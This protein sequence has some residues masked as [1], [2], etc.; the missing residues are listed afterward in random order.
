MLPC[1]TANIMWAVIR[2]IRTS[3]P[4]CAILGGVGSEKQDIPLCFVLVA[5]SC[6]V[7]MQDLIVIVMGCGT[8]SHFFDPVLSADGEGGQEVIGVKQ[9]VTAGALDVYTVRQRKLYPDNLK[10]IM[11]PQCYRLISTS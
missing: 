6:C 7:C 4:C 1:H 8:Q 2:A 9:R 3:L 11:E 5:V 10:T